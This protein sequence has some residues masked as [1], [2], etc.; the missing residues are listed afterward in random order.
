MDKMSSSDRSRVM[1]RN[2]GEDT[3]PELSLR[4]A[5]FAEGF[6]YRL[7]VKELPGSPDL[8]F[9]KF[10][11]VIQIHGCYWHAHDCGRFNWPATNAE[12]WRNKL[13]KNRERDLKNLERI[14]QLGW[15]QMTVWECAFR[16]GSEYAP[17]E[18]V[19]M[20]VG[21]LKNGSG[22]KVIPQDSDAISWGKL[23]HKKR[24][25]DSELPPDLYS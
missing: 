21:W 9:P 14:N 11:A 24:P 12:F 5:I 20:V 25:T 22:N 4:R 7:H 10:Q 15:R 13:E 19:E 8:V 17:S 18:V 6:R 2:K 3:G 23:R 16:R 1:S